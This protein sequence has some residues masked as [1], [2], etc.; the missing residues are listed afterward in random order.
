MAT[1]RVRRRST[2]RWPACWPEHPPSAPARW[3]ARR[4][5]ALAGSSFWP[6]GPARNDGRYEGGIA[7]A[8]LD[9]VPPRGGPANHALPVLILAAGGRVPDGGGLG[10]AQAPLD[11]VLLDIVGLLER[12]AVR[13]PPARCD[14]R[15]LTVAILFQR[16]GGRLFARDG[17]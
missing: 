14:A 16:A 1:I 9:V 10:A 6:S 3:E 12:Q 7:H 15:D 13:R 2:P 11:A 8:A 17:I 5:A 4:P